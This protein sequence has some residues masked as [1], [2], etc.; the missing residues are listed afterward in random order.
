[1]KVEDNNVWI[2]NTLEGALSKELLNSSIRVSY[3]EP[4]WDGVT[5]A[6][7]IITLTS[8]LNTILGEIE[9]L[10]LQIEELK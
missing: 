3:D 8:L 6:Y 7:D 2:E 5:R 9:D 1:M 10:K 4:C